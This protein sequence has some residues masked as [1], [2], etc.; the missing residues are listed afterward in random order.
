M[1]KAL[2]V[3]SLLSRCSLCYISEMEGLRGQAGLLIG[4]IQG[5]PGELHAVVGP[6][7]NL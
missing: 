2:N 6:N 5:H 3:K 7:K 1:L 4:L